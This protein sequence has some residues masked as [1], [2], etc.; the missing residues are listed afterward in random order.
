M[1]RPATPRAFTISPRGGPVQLDANRLGRVAFDVQNVSGRQLLCQPRVVPLRG[2]QGSWVSVLGEPVRELADR[3]STEVL[4]DVALP[5]TAPSATYALRLDAVG[6]EDPDEYSATGPEVTV[7]LGAPP[8]GRPTGR[9]YVAT[10]A[11]AVAGGVAGLLVGTLPATLFLIAARGE[12]PDTAGRSL[13]EAIGLLIGN[14]LATAL[15]GALLL[16]LGALVGMWAGP[17]AGAWLALRIRAYSARALT[18]VLLAVFIPVWA[19]L[20]WIALALAFSR[21]ESDLSAVPIL[22]GIALTLGVPP[23]AARGLAIAIRRV[24]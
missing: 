21:L 18:V 13:G 20:V 15:V 23:L 11:G 4:V 9:G 5:A 17:V 24:P 12:P 22:L 19:T 16:V 8:L 10:A 6:V 1:T 14:A 2:A 7:E 3:E